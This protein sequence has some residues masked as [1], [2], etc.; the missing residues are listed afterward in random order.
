MGVDSS[1]PDVRSNHLISRLDQDPEDAEKRDQARGT[2]CNNADSDCESDTSEV[3]SVGSEPTPTSVVG[4]RVCGTMR[5]DQ[6]SA[7]SRGEFRD[8]ENTRTSATPSPSSSASCND[9]YYQRASSNHVP[10]PSPPGYSQPPS[11]PTASSVRSPASS[12]ATASSPGR[13]EAIQEAI[14]PRYQSSHQQ[15]LLK[16]GRAHV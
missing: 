1:D 15:H 4:V 16:I 3:L 12:S 8:E 14:V 10:A 9:L 6:E 2:E 7:S 11:S 13:P 5:Y